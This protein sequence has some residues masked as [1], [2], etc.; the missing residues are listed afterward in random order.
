MNVTKLIGKRDDF[1]LK[2]IKLVDS[3]KDGN[4]F[5]KRELA[6]A[7]G[8]ASEGTV[9]KWCRKHPKLTEYLCYVPINEGKHRT[10]IFVNKKY[11]QQL[12]D[13]K[14]ATEIY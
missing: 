10:A 1:Y 6:L 7:F 5:T 12:L 11:R 13:N 9:D 3:Q 4:G 8:Y 2:I 14:Q